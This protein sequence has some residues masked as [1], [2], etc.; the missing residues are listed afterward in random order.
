MVAV[1]SVVV[2]FGGLSV[3]VALVATVGAAS[4]DIP[5]VVGLFNAR[6]L[7]GTVNGDNLRLGVVAVSVT[8]G[9]SGGVSVSGLLGVSVGRSGGVSVSGLLGVAVGGLRV[10]V[11]GLRVAVGGLR[12]AV[13]V[14]AIIVTVTVRVSVTVRVTVTV[15][16]IMTV[17][18]TVTVLAKTAGGFAVTVG[19][20]SVVVVSIVVSVVVVLT[21]E[22]SLT[23]RAEVVKTI[24]TVAGLVAV[25]TDELVEG[26]GGVVTV[27]LNGGV[28]VLAV[29][30]DGGGQIDASRG[31]LGDDLL[32]GLNRDVH[33][34]KLDLT[35][36]DGLKG[37]ELL[38][39]DGESL[40][41]TA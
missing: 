9:G 14:V 26:V 36:R 37:G 2:V 31:V 24:G 8:V 16:V 30:V 28:L 39:L 18:V 13:A 5:V 15:R 23:D 27:V 11:G 21:V 7:V 20:L 34:T 41:S 38:P 29:N 25:S 35:D 40:A 12:V 33:V 32:V 10:A 3:G 1:C 17:R 4:V 6:V 22:G 19:V